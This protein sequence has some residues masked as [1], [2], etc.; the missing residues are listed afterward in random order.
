MRN[1]RW[2]LPVLLCLFAGCLTPKGDTV[3]EKRAHIDRLGE[4]ALQSVIAQSPEVTDKIANAYGYGV[5]DL[6][7][8]ALFLIGGAGNGYGVVIDNA[9]KT[10]YYMRLVK[11]TA[12]LGVGIKRSRMVIIFH[13][14]K[15]FEKFKKNGWDVSI[16]SDAAA[17]G[18]KRGGEASGTGSMRRG[19]DVYQYTD[20]GLFLRTALEGTIFGRLK[21]LNE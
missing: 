16:Q 19:M 20:R 11:G 10:P 3:L 17:K 12:G 14:E 1:V 9:T 13:D 2:G 15:T 18:K 7:G 8:T 6:S 21:K 5:F 4:A